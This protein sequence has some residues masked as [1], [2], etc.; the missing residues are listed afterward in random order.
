MSVSQCV[1]NN[2]L[3]IVDGVGRSAACVGTWC[4]VDKIPHRLSY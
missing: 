2:A 4:W 3:C 1:N